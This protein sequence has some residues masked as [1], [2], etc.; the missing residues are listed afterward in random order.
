MASKCLYKKTDTNELGVTS[1][2]GI[3][4]PYHDT[5]PAT[6]DITS[7][8]SYTA[9]IFAHLGFT[10]NGGNPNKYNKVYGDNIC[11]GDN[12]ATCI[13][14]Y[15]ELTTKP[16]VNANGRWNVRGISETK[17]EPGSIKSLNIWFCS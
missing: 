12:K 17:H 1:G 7:G 8:K 13:K 2:E 15:V 6:F 3:E 11:V 14:K 16:V 10:S 9:D 5:L 4:C